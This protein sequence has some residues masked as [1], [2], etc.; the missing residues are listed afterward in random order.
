MFISIIIIML[1]LVMIFAP[2]A[3]FEAIAMVLTPFALAFAVIT[4]PILFIGLVIGWFIGKKKK[5][6]K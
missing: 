5:G 1:I 6:D 4:L 2:F 3:Y